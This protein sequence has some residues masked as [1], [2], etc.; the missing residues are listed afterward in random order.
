MI[1]PTA[2]PRYD[3][4]WAE[5]AVARIAADCSGHLGLAARHL[6]TGEELSWQP[7]ATVG[8]ASAVKVG[9]QAAVMRAA[10]LGVL[11]LSDR[12]PL[13]EADRTGGSG[14]LALLSPGLEFTVA[15]LITLMITLSDN[16]ATNLLIRLCGGAAAVTSALAE[17]GFPGIRV[18]RPI[19]LA[20][21]RLDPPMLPVRGVRDPAEASPG[22][23]PGDG[24]F[25]TAAPAD[26]CDLMAALAAG[27]VV[28]A[29]AS[30]QMI[31]V[32]RQQQNQ[33][34]FPRAFT[35]IADPGDAADALAPALANKA[36]WT[37][38]R[39]V[40]TGLIFLP[41]GGTVAYAAAAENLADQTMTALAEGDELLGRLGAVVLAR[42]WPRGVPV[43]V[44]PGWLPAAH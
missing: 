2:A 42:W 10:R 16:T 29:A 1:G 18:A 3:A 9:I 13:T 17:L 36:G 20:P 44:R 43:P 35:H 32:L 41:G 26:L 24:P 22:A 34:L 19:Q 33:P 12:V 30:A 5:A 15:D 37:S 39:R 8:T 14:V 31:A 7:R 11:S 40:D 27:T 21:Q 28:D 4:A 6:E 25:A 38:G 23:P